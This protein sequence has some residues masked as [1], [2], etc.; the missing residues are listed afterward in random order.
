[1]AHSWLSA[2]LG[3]TAAASNWF[4]IYINNKKMAEKVWNQI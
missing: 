1:M 4:S 3:D 2:E